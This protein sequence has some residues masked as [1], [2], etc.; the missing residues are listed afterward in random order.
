MCG[1]RDA[2]PYGPHVSTDAFGFAATHIRAYK[3]KRNDYALDRHV[4][5]DLTLVGIRV[6]LRGSSIVNTSAASRDRRIESSDS[7]ATSFQ[8]VGATTF[9]IVWAE[10]VCRMPSTTTEPPE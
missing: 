7:T 3:T 4:G 8:G 6:R 1:I 9:R 2:T 10:T 5:R